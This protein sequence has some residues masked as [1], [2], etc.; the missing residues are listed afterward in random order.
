MGELDEVVINREHDI[1]NGY[2]YGGYGLEG[3]H[4]PLM[5]ADDGMG[6]D[7]GIIL[8]HDEEPKPETD[9][10]EDELVQTSVRDPSPYEGIF[11]KKDP[12]HDPTKEDAEEELAQS[13]DISALD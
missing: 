8:R 9:E 2:K 4:N 12:F 5:D 7:F 3:W 11:T 13:G 10:V 6:D 1:A